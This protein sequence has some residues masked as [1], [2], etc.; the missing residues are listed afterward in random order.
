MADS[1]TRVSD[2]AF[3][4]ECHECDNYTRHMW[5]TRHCTVRA[6]SLECA[7]AFDLGAGAEVYD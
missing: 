5:A 4:E 6:C 7:Q 3:M 2:S 1:V